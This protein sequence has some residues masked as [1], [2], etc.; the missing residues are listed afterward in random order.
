[1]EDIIL[2]PR[3]LQTPEDAK[4]LQMTVELSHQLGIPTNLATISWADRIGLM[5]LPFGRALFTF[6]EM[7]LPKTLMGKLGPEEWRPLIA[8]SLIFHRKLRRKSEL[9]FVVRMV[10]PIAPV[11]VMMLTVF[12]ALGEHPPPFLIVGFIGGLLSVYLALVAL[13]WSSS[14]K[15]MKRMAL[16][17]DSQAIEYVGREVFLEVLRKLESLGLEEKGFRARLQPRPTIRERIQSLEPSK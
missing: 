4:I 15:H 2:G 5:K 7:I 6:G 12:P 11:M 13:A 14:W 17:A 9:G 3:S 1:M 16:K 10:L 8:S